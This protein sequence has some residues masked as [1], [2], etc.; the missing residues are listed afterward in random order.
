[1]VRIFKVL[2]AII[3]FLSMTFFGLG[4]LPEYGG[5]AHGGFA[6]ASLSTAFMVAW[7]ELKTVILSFNKK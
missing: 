2:K 3:F 4:I 1:M 5:V 6:F 7:S